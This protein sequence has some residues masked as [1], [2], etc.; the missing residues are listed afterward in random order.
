MDVS[1]AAAAIAA[2]FDPIPHRSATVIAA[3][4]RGTGPAIASSG[5][6]IARS[7]IV[8]DACWS[9]PAC[10]AVATSSQTI[11]SARSSSP[12]GS[13]RLPTVS[14]P[15]AVTWVPGRIQSTSRRGVRL[16]VAVM[17][18]SAQETAPGRS[19]VAAIPNSSAS[20]RLRSASRPQRV[21]RRCGATCACACSRSALLGEPSTVIEQP[22]GFAA[23][24]V[25]KEQAS[26]GGAVGEPAGGYL[27]HDPVAAVDVTALDVQF[28][29]FGHTQLDG[30]RLD[31]AACT[32]GDECGAD[33]VDSL[34]PADGVAQLVRADDADHADRPSR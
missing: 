21:M 31:D 30:G 13:S 17:T 18:T 4:L 15:R 22:P 20:A 24:G 9:S 19:V 27:D 8:R 11:R 25:E 6:A 3:G 26:R 16:L 34:V 29:A 23:G 14:A 12:R 28:A 32:E 10:R 7:W 33:S 2:G 5:H 1:R